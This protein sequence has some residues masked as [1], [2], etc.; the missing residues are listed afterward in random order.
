MPMI[1]RQSIN[2]L[3][4]VQNIKSEI[5]PPNSEI[6]FLLS[7]QNPNFA[8]AEKRNRIWIIYRD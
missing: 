1:K 5:E 6:H 3:I 8:L 4:M 7:P 2:P